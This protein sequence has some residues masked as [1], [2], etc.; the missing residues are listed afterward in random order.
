VELI[1]GSIE[2]FLELESEVIDKKENLDDG[3]FQALRPICVYDS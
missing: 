3:S 1:K 2:E